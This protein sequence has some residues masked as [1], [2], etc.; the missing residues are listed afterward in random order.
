MALS[1]KQRKALIEARLNDPNI[2][3]KEFITL[4]Q[5]CDGPGAHLGKKKPGRSRKEKEPVAD[6][7]KDGP[8]AKELT[9]EEPKSVDEWVR[10]IERERHEKELDER[11][12]AATVPEAAGKPVTYAERVIYERECWE[13]LEREKA[14]K[15]AT[16][17][18]GKPPIFTRPIE[19]RPRR[20][21]DIEN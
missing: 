4:L 16:P 7:P 13:R 12:E 2:S 8:V 3:T 19:E 21:W 18:A 6:P 20:N 15:A 5:M 10:E 1:K 14:N 9:A 17:K 11:R